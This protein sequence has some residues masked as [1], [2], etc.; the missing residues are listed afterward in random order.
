[1]V[2]NKSKDK[3][4]DFYAISQREIPFRCKGEEG[5]WRLSPFSLR[6]ELRFFVQ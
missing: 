2:N 4:Q 6:G 5:A 1:M 3:G